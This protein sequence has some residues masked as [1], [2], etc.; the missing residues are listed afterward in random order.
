ML[1]FVSFD[2]VGLL[3]LVLGMKMISEKKILSERFEFDNNNP[4]RPSVSKPQQ[5][6]IDLVKSKL[7]SGEYSLQSSPC[8]CGATGADDLI[9]SEIER[10]GLPLTSVLCT[11]CGT[12][13]TDPYLSDESLADFYTHIY[14]KM[15]GYDVDN[16]SGIRDDYIASQSGYAK[17]LLNLAGDILTPESFICEIG[18]G[19]GGGVKYFQDQGYNAIGCDYDVAALE[20]GREQGVE[21][22]YFGDL[23]SL[24]EH[25]GEVK[26]DLIYLHHVFEH[27]SDPVEFLK[28]SQKYLTSKGRII[29]IVPDISRIDQ[30]GHPAAIGNLL[31]YLHIAHKYN[32]TLEGLQQLAHRA[33]CN[34]V[35]LEP[36]QSIKT[37]WAES[38][39]LWVQITPGMDGADAMNSNGGMSKTVGKE[40]LNYLQRT[41]RLFSL[42]LCRGQLSQKLSTLMSPAKLANKVKRTLAAR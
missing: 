28:V 21:N 34:C 10:Y 32:F 14:R 5:E 42:G 20:A 37:R 25:L 12:V 16:Q 33:G 30:F 24:K 38:P 7:D 4:Y 27:L 6:L 31:M 15:Y 17:R 11:N 40:T 22:L 8:P 36:D 41:E 9:I 19:G 29:L 26:F 13:R 18:C 1:H 35:P 2:F 23:S 39:E 3:S